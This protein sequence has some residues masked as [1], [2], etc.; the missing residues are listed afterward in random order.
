MKKI[1][2]V[3]FLAILASCH[4][5]QKIE[6]HN[7]VEIKITDNY[8]LHELKNS[9]YLLVLFPG[10][11]STASDTKKE[12][13]ILTE[14]SKQ[15][16]SVLLMNFN[17]H[18]W[19]DEN[20]TKQLAEDFN[21]ILSENKLNHKNI[22]IGGMSIGGNV[23]ITLSDVLVKEKTIDIKGVFIVDSPIDLYAL[24]ESSINDL[25]R[26]ELDAE[27]K[28]EPQFIVDYFRENFGDDD[29]FYSN[30]QKVSPFMLKTKNINVNNLKNTRLRFYTE[31]DENWWKENRQ[32][33]YENTNAY[34]IQQIAHQLKAE[35]WN[36]FQLIETENKGYR[37]NG[38]RHPHSW[39]IVDAK[40]LISWMK[41]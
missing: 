6:E 28:S 4:R 1:Y 18:I 35:N 11:G 12:F 22:Y 27:R 15:N 5:N 25:K 10:G 13:E 9:D 40:E 36:N 31:P 32:T 29:N 16:V 17:R 37:A 19:I 2:F 34:Q 26:P 7:E 38:E 24:Y 8:E 39:S 14:A 20:T 30:I 23:A 33:A 21:A 3:L 41:N